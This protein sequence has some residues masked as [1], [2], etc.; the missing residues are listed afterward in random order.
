[1]SDVNQVYVGNLKISEDVLATIA[2]QATKEVK[3]VA[4]ITGDGSYFSGIIKKTTRQNAVKVELS[5]DS[6]VVEMAI[7]LEPGA[8]IPEV[9]TAIQKNVKESIQNMTGIAVSKVNIIVQGIE[10]EEENA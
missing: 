10:F 5:E 2:E 1:M 9:S 7:K 6:A 8:S 3:G 4:K